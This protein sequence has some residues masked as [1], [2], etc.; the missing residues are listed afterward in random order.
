M[1]RIRAELR[2]LRHLR[3]TPISVGR[4]EIRRRRLMEGG[5]DGSSSSGEGV[6][7][8]EGDDL[9]MP[10]SE[11]SSAAEDL[12]EDATL[13][14]LRCDLVDLEVTEREEEEMAAA[15]AELIEKAEAEA[16]KLKEEADKVT[17][18]LMEG[19][20]TFKL[21]E[22]EDKV[23]VKHTEGENTFKLKEEE[24]NAN[25]KGKMEI[26]TTTTAPVTG[27]IPEPMDVDLVILEQA[28]P[29]HSVVGNT[30]AD[31]NTIL[32]VQSERMNEK[33]DA[34]RMDDDDDKPLSLVKA[35]YVTKTLPWGDEVIVI[36]NDSDIGD[37]DDE[38]EEEA[39]EV[40]SDDS[41][42]FSIG[43]FRDVN[44]N[45]ETEDVD[46][47]NNT[48]DDSEDGSEQEE[49]TGGESYN[50]LDP[51]GATPNRYTVTVELSFFNFVVFFVYLYIVS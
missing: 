4:E 39:G 50:A 31:S 34:Q 1:I 30:A 45:D 26:A 3:Q 40:G 5:S 14:R 24:D 47:D 13:E 7:S 38:E 22:G 37:E 44:S 21:K 12:D 10:D 36:G 32:G 51:A 23:T 17:V 46:D 6:T 48:E 42:D 28:H 49:P 16:A 18:K 20:N 27:D 11:V 41:S 9:S 2:A 19:E 25:D 33:S 43:S 29:I 15:A 35:E 8:D